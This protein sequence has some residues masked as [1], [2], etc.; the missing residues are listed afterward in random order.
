MAAGRWFV[1]LLLLVLAGSLARAQCVAGEG[2]TELEVDGI[3]LA[4]FEGFETD[5]ASGSVDLFGAVCVEDIGGTWLLRA[6]RVSITG[7]RGEQ[8]DARLVAEQASIAFQGWRVEAAVA[9]AEVDA[10]TVIDV[11]ISGA[12]VVG[13]AAAVQYDIP[14]GTARIADVALRGTVFRATAAEGFLE[15]DVLTLGE[16]V[17]TTCACEIEDSPYTVAATSAQVDLAT[18][19]FVIEDGV[20]RALGLVVPLPGRLALSGDS[21]EPVETPLVV[22]SQEQDEGELG[23]GVTVFAPR[24][25]D[26]DDVRFGAGVTSLFGGIRPVASLTAETE[27]LEAERVEAVVAIPA[28]GFIVDTTVARELGAGARLSVAFHNRVTPVDHYLHQGVLTVERDVDLPVPESLG[29]ATLG[30]DA[31]AAVSAQT[32]AGEVVAGPRLGA[33]TSVTYTSPRTAAGRF[34]VRTGVG[35]TLYPVQDAHQ[36][37]ATLVPSWVARTGPLEVELGHVQRQVVG[38]SPFAASLDRV[39]PASRTTARAA[40]DTAWGDSALD[41]QFTA[42]YDHLPSVVAGPGFTTLEVAAELVQTGGPGAVTLFGAFQGAALLSDRADEEPYLEGG[43]RYAWSGHEVAA[44]VRYD[45]E[46]R[47]LTD[48]ELSGR[49]RIPGDDVTVTPF[50]AL[51]VAP[52]FQGFGPELTGHGVAVEWTSCCG[53]L[54]VGY[55]Q[56]LDE[57]RTLL[58]FRVDPRPLADLEEP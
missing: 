10:I 1:C 29:A 19:R 45:L 26:E 14:N 52:V 21:A 2:R 15:G 7:L 5:R 49:V 32:I 54:V 22:E 11:R 28:E 34:R 24:L 4:T 23:E 17:A 57:F 36:I 25:Y 12:N 42:V 35:A 41:M 47:A 39:S 27:R 13:T 3:G 53:T 51:D 48:A 20:L 55:E 50:L 58:S 43:T 37:V 38:R 30:M 16:I 18:S 40:L 33:A 44:R 9:F 31:F 56:Y 6:D 8:P 46:A